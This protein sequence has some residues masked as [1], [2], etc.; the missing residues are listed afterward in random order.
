M[1]PLII[2][3]V[4]V[5]AKSLSKDG[6]P[7]EA[8]AQVQDLAELIESGSC[9]LGCE[10]GSTRIKATLISPAG[11]PLASGAWGWENSLVD[12]YWTYRL[13]E[14]WEGTAACLADLKAQINSRYGIALEGFAAGGISAMMHGYL[15]FD[16]RGNLLVPFRT[17]RNN[18]TGKAAAELTGLFNF[19]IPQRWSIAHLHQ[20]VLNG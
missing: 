18:T 9:F 3:C 7:M 17:W 4:Y 1:Q 14:V 10:L 8:K 5:N 2:L 12:G 19:A 13:D 6:N 20:A 16:R 15:A 11:V